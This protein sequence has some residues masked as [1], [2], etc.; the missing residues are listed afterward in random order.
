MYVQYICPTKKLWAGLFYFIYCTPY[1]QISHNVY[2]S[3][4]I[5][6]CYHTYRG[7]NQL[8]APLWTKQTN[9][10][11]W[12]RRTDICS[13]SLVCTY[14]YVLVLVPVLLLYK[15]DNFGYNDLICKA[16]GENLNFSSDCHA[17]PISEYFIIFLFFFIK[18]VARI[19]SKKGKER[20]R[21]RERSW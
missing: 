11:G 5:S 17:A 7:A 19:S 16:G 10:T 3:I 21:E 4:R 9:S 12:V 18:Y 20:E 14:M 2:V 15:Y 1:I 8:N 6:I 13:F